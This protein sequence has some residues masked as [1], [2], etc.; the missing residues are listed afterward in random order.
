MTIERIIHLFH[1]GTSQSL[2][3]PH[4]FELPTDE[5][6]IRKEGERLVIEPVK[7]SS[8]LALLATLPD[9]ADEFP[10]VDMGLLPIDK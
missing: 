5:V 10:D 2:T 1:D 6:I 7:R 8:L 4:E 9:I 3:I